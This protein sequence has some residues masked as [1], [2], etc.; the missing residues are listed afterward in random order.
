MSGFPPAGPVTLSQVIPSYLYKQYED[1]ENLQALVAAFNGMA[2]GYVDWFK[3]VNLPVYT[4][5]TIF[6]ALL[7]W[8]AQGLYGISRPLLPS[9]LTQAIGTLNTY[10]LNRLTLNTYQIIG[11]TNYYATTDDVFKR[12][13]TWH[14]YKGDGKV[15]DIRWLKRRVMRF[16]IGANGTAPEI[17][18]T[19]QISISFGVGNQV[20][21][22]I[23]QDITSATGGAFPNGMQLNTTPLNAI[24]TVSQRFP[25][26]E[27]SPVFKAAV[28]SGVLEL[29]F[30]FTWVVDV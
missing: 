29:P 26:F 17:D 23:I 11:S 5:G 13:I 16:L 18:N 15:F 20:N 10:T 25:A 4:S 7:D 9:G 21:I 12:I 14:F 19:Y 30:Q 24:T 3:S 22:R 6:G 8:V 27:M 2:Q 1:D 28:E